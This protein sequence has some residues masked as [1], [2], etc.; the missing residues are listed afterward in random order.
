MDPGLDRGL[1]E[2]RA[3]SHAHPR[4]WRSVGPGA[5][6]QGLVLAL[7]L[8]GAILGAGCGWRGS[9]SR[10]CLHR[11]PGRRF[12]SIIRRVRLPE[13]ASPETGGIVPPGFPPN[14]DFPKPSLLQTSFSP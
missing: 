3:A 5:P 11:S 12:A 9:Q 4:P 6:P 14:K 2:A 1:P 13:G 7:G 10:S 8:L